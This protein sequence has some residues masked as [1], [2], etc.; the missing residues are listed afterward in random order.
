MTLAIY[1]GGALIEPKLGCV[2]PDNS[3]TNIFK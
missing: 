1:V 2:R 3:V